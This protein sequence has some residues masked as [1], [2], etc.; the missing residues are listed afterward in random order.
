MLYWGLWAWDC[1]LNFGWSSLLKQGNTYL[2]LCLCATSLHIHKL[3]FLMQSF[4]FNL[5]SKALNPIDPYWA[6]RK[7]KSTLCCTLETLVWV[8]SQQH[9][10]SDNDSLGW[11]PPA[12]GQPKVRE[13]LAYDRR[14]AGSNVR[15]SGM[16]LGGDSERQ[17]LLHPLTEKCTGEENTH[18]A[19]MIRAL[20]WILFLRG[21]CFERVACVSIYF[22]YLQYFSLVCVPK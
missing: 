11:H 21:P 3:E 2:C 12:Q 7:T 19:E 1:S 4:R 14:V 13:V 18:L 16:K 8:D 22:S 15:A 10:S 20:M 6:N 5:I 9:R 17:L